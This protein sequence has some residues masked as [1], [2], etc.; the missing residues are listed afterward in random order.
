MSKIKAVAEG[1]NTAGTRWL[2]AKEEN[3]TFR[4]YVLKERYAGH[5]RGGSI[6][7]WCQCKDVY[8]DEQEARK[9]FEKKLKGK[10]K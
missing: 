2:L 4:L 6:F 10:L 1:K 8:S 9:A 5:V 3:N 7:V